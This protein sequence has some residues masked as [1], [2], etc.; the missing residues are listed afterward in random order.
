MEEK[1]KASAESDARFKMTYYEWPG[2]ALANE[3]I[4]SRNIPS[5][6]KIEV[7]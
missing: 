1:L 4:E 3:W 2:E 6:T 7:R 5:L